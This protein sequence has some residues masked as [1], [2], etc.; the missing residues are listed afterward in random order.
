MLLWMI[1]VAGSVCNGN[2]LNSDE[3]FYITVICY[4]WHVAWGWYFDSRRREKYE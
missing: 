2:A 3:W 1:L 4:V